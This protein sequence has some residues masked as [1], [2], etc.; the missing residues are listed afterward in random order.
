MKVHICFGEYVIF[1]LQYYLR[2]QDVPYAILQTQQKR[3]DF[4]LTPEDTLQR[5]SFERDVVSAE[6]ANELAMITRIVYL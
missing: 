1:V 6:F 2:T 5:T 3:Q 4:F